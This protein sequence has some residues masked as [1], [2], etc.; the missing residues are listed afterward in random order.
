MDHFCPIEN[1]KVEVQEPAVTATEPRQVGIAVRH[2]LQQKHILVYNWYIPDN[3]HVCMVHLPNVVKYTIDCLGMICC[4]ICLRFLA[5]QSRLVRSVLVLSGF[6]W[7]SQVICLSTI[8]MALFHW[9]LLICMQ[10]IYM[11]NIVLHLCRFAYRLVGVY[12]S[13]HSRYVNTI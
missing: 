9:R 12:I 10:H 4:I 11:Y 8:G 3:L 2:V 6:P 7:S 5:K 1:G 13:Y